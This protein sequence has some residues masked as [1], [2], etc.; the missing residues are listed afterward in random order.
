MSKPISSTGCLE[1]F[2]VTGANAYYR[3]EADIEQMNPRRVHEL[4]QS[5]FQ[6]ADAAALSWVNVCDE[7]GTL[8][9]DKA[10]EALYKPFLQI[11]AVEVLVEVHRKLG[12]CVPI[13]ELVPYLSQYAGQGNIRITDMSF[14]LFA[15]VAINGVA[16]SWPSR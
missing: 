3:P 13:A 7:R 9:A 11:G 16:A 1:P 6:A 12:D 10:T 14:S 4:M 15:N 2:T 5:H 8:L